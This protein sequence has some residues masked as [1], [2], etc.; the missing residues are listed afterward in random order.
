MDTLRVKWSNNACANSKF[1]TSPDILFPLIDLQHTL[2]KH[3]HIIFD[4]L[5]PRFYIVKL[6]LTGVYIIFHIS[7]QNIDCGHSLKPSRRGGSNEYPHS[8]F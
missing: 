4:P 6:G 5:K 3:A 2:R 7:A 1:W 8:M